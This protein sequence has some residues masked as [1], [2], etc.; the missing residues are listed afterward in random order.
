MVRTLQELPGMNASRHN[1]R[2]TIRLA[3][4]V[5]TTLIEGG[6]C[7]SEDAIA[8]RRIAGGLNESRA[9]LDDLACLVI[10]RE[11]EALSIKNYTDSHQREMP[12][13]FTDPAA[14]LD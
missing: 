6:S 14:C 10:H 13:Q 4:R 9:P 7:S 5:L 1:P 12:L 2:E 11:R 8:L 3:L